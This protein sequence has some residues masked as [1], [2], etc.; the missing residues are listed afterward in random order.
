MKLDESAS[1]A[2]E[3]LPVHIQPGI[4]H[5]VEEGQEVGSFLEA[6]IS[7]DLKE[8]LG[9][10][11]IVNR[12]HLFDIV[13]WFYNHAPSPCWGSPEKYQKWIAEHQMVTT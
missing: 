9:R 8:S 7:N 10:A 4:R 13:S 5:Y 3:L 11:D 2:L 1:E 12:E 6:V